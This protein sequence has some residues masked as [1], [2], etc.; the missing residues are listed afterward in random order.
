MKPHAIAAL[1]AA[2][3]VAHVGA[4]SASITPVGEFVGEAW[5]TFE[6]IGPIGTTPGP[7]SILNGTATL[8]DSLANTLMIANSLYSFVTETQILPWNGN[9]MGGSLTGFMTI[10]FD[11]P[12]VQFGGY[13]GTADIHNGGTINFYDANNQFI[14]ADAFPL[15]L[16]Q[17]VWKGWSSTTPIGRIEIYADETPNPPFVMDDFQVNYVPAPGPVAMLAL[18]GLAAARRRRM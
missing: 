9:L 1:T 6:L 17:W 8:Y 3:L 4:A 16:G 13:F 14:G 11:I 12:V 5:E 7:A 2:A 15:D 10:E 18:A